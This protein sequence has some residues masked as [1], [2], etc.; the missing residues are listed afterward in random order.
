MARVPPRSVYGGRDVA[1]IFGRDSSWKGVFI[2]IVIIGEGH[3]A[4]TPRAAESHG[5]GVPWGNRVV[6]DE[7]V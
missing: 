1:L 6:E 4:G 7:A 2:G 3:R 5:E